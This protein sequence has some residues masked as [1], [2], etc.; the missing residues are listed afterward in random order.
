MHSIV[1]IHK[2]HQQLNKLLMSFREVLVPVIL[3]IIVWIGIFYLRLIVIEKDKPK[4][5][6]QKRVQK[7]L[8]VLGV[9]ATL[10]IL[11]SFLS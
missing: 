6:V 9:I 10:S 5:E 3:V 8:I 11:G 4:T 1:C 7:N 2:Q